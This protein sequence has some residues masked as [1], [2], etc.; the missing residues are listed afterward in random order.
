MSSPTWLWL[1]WVKVFAKPQMFRIVP[2][3]VY[4]HGSWHSWS[5]IIQDLLHQRFCISFIIL[6]KLYR[7]SKMIQGL[8]QFQFRLKLERLRLAP[9]GNGSTKYFNQ[10]QNYLRG[11]NKNDIRNWLAWWYIIQQSFSMYKQIKKK[12]MKKNYSPFYPTYRPNNLH[13]TCQK[14]DRH[15]GGKWLF[16]GPTTRTTSHK[17]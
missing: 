6:L 7:W 5:S 13:Y 17:A 12:Q 16:D 11:E 14:L 4:L 9:M 3:W 10:L 15:T 8:L 2:D 1:T